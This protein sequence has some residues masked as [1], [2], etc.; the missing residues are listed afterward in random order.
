MIFISFKSVKSIIKIQK[1]LRNSFVEALRGPLFS[2]T[3]VINKPFT[4]NFMMNTSDMLCY[5]LLIVDGL[6]K[7]TSSVVL[8]AGE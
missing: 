6:G 7:W 3:S 5:S 4:L 1:D 2:T 8:Q